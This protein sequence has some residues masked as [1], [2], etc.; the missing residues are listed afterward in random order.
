MMSAPLSLEKLLYDLVQVEAQRDYRQDPDEG[1]DFELA[2]KLGARQVDEDDP[3]VW[4]VVLVI[5]IPRAEGKPVPPYVVKLSCWSMFRLHDSAMAEED[6]RRLVW[7][8]GGS[9]VYSMA[10]EYL[11]M[12]TARGPWG[13]YFLPTISLRGSQPATDEGQPAPP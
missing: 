1:A 13:P 3:A 12:L 4:N 8:T 11:A 7:V 5:E 9:I 10:R 6:A 2:L